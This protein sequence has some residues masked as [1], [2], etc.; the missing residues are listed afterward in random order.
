LGQVLSERW[1]VP[2]IATV[3]E[4]MPADALRK[5]AQDLSVDLIVMA[6]H[7]RGPLPR[8]W[9][10]SVANALVRTASTPLLLV[11]PHEEPC[12]LL[13]S[14]HACVFQRILIPLDGS[15]ASERILEPA[16]ALGALMGAEYTLLQAVTPPMLG[17]SPAAST[18]QFDEWMLQ[19]WQDEV[20]SYLERVAAPM[21]ERGLTVT[22]T[23]PLGYPATAIHEYAHAHAVDLIAMA[24]HGRGGVGRVILGSVA[25]E[26]VRD[27]GIPVL[28][29]RPREEG[30]SREGKR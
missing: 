6:T 12:D 1:E 30:V 13:E 2:I 10:G 8:L 7:A 9:L 4:G 25:E 24:T 28:V 20:T 14:L 23:A 11:R 17:Y 15:T 21:R 19:Q 29:Y 16:I 18:V 27:A 26:V 3:L 5:R 22:T